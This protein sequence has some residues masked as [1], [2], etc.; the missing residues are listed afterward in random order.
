MGDVAKGAKLFK[1]RAAQC[2]LAQAGPGGHGVGPNLW[3]IVGSKSGGKNDYNYTEANKNSGVTWTEDALF[4]YLENPKKY[5]P[6][7]KM[8]FA[9][10]K[11]EKERRD[12]I[13]YLATL[14]D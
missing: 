7:T 6:G 4:E 9:G 13:A 14:H 12:L 11:S 2:H 1:S 10:M 5:I 8:S 3:G